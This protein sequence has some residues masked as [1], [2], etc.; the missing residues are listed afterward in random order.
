M[1]MSVF[2]FLEVSIKII[3]KI[4]EETKVVEN[5]LIDVIDF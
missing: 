3:K 2:I 1:N 4:K 5:T